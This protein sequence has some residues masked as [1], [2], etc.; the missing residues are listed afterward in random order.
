MKESRRRESLFRR[1]VTTR[2][3]PW[4]EY[5]SSMPKYGER[6][7]REIGIIGAENNSGKSM[8]TTWH[9]CISDLLEDHY[10][11]ENDKLLNE[12]AFVLEHHEERYCSRKDCSQKL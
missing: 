9:G 7:R 5:K 10:H 4:K 6:I 8:H 12:Y 3:L 11:P 1:I 2:L